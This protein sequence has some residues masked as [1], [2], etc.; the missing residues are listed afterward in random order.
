MV[1]ASQ[2]ESTPVSSDDDPSSQG[3]GSAVPR[4]DDRI[5][6]VIDDLFND[7]KG[8]IGLLLHSYPD[9]DAMCA[10]FAFQWLLDHRWGLDADIL[11][12]GEVSHPQNRTAKNVL[13]IR[14]DRVSG[15]GATNEIKS[16]Y[17]AFVTLD[18]IP[19][20][21]GLDVPVDLV[22]DHH[23]QSCNA[24][25][26]DIRPTGST[27]A[28]IW[29]YLDEY[30]IDLDDCPSEVLTA[31]VF[32]IDN[33]THRLV[34]ENVS[35]LDRTAHAELVHHIDRSTMRSIL[36]YP[37]P[38]YLFDLRVRAAEHQYKDGSV[39]VSGLGILDPSQRDALP[40]IADEFLRLEGVETVIVFGIVDEHIQASV[41][42]RNSSVNVPTL[43]Q[44]VFGDRFSGGKSGSGG[45]DVPIGPMYSADDPES[46]QQ[47]VWEVLERSVRQRIMRHDV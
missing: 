35:E 41:R 21:T 16:S 20:D 44:R 8:P 46:L 47:E 42:S 29:G 7:L 24:P 38:Q 27:C 45:A 14:M 6:Q 12:T 22:I 3:E 13:D 28:I 5:Y 11:Y 30:D 34:S 17:D 32:G 31:L 26:V 10:G 1:S 23:H 19:R 4:H 43:C 39:L 18:C 25:V 36:L 40:H 37:L 2:P 33:D 9:P 15:D